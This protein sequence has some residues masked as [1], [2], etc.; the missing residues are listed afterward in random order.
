MLYEKQKYKTIKFV[1]N[2]IMED[3]VYCIIFDK[4]SGE[5]ENVNYKKWSETVYTI[6]PLFRLPTTTAVQMLTTTHT[7]SDMAWY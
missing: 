7:H 4:I 5:M 3:D 2:Y 6:Y 1:K